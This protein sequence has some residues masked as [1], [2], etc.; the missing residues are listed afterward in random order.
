VTLSILSA[1]EVLKPRAEFRVRTDMPELL[2][3]QTLE[4]CPKAGLNGL[5]QGRRIGAADGATGFRDPYELKAI[6]EGR[7]QHVFY[8]S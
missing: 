1:G 7:P 5:P 2:C 3:R 6:R 8:G 4:K